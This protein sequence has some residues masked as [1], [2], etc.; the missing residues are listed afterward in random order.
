MKLLRA[1]VA[2]PNTWLER[3]VLNGQNQCC[4]KQCKQCARLALSLSCCAFG[5]DVLI[6]FFQYLMQDTICLLRLRSRTLRMAMMSPIGSP[7]F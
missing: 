6:I 3:A 4:T 7:S 5:G 2:R 1:L